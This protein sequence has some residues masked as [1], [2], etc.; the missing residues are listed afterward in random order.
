MN[1]TL[2]DDLPFSSRVAL[3]VGGTRG[4]GHA[5]ARML[6][7]AGAT[8]VLTGTDRAQAERE[9]Q[10]LA[11]DYGVKAAGLALELRDFASIGPAIKS[12]A[13]EHNGIDALVMSAGVLHN[14]PLGLIEESVA[15]QV[16]DVNL[17]GAI[18]VLQAC[19]KVMMR[20][21]RGAIVLL[22]S[23]VGERGAAGQ[24]VYAASKAGIAALARSA[25]KELGP[26]G[27]RVNAVAPGL[28][29]TDLLANVPADVITARCAQTSLRRLGSA[30]EVATTIRFLLSDDA[31]FITGQVLGVDGG[32][33]L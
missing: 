11:A 26:L 15:R 6:A 33:I 1:P 31:S 24:A 10:H 21:R 19:A 23:L 3:V 14:T 12:I 4:I 13:A 7:A 17:L 30:T 5:C 22:A 27:I 32:L 16:L 29:E 28:I 8:V 9:A 25:A 2:S 18:E 20:R